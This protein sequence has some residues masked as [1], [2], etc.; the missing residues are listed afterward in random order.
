[1][2]TVIGINATHR[3]EVVKKI[4]QLLSDEFVLFVKTL[5]AHWN[6]EGNDFYNKHSF[7]E[8][9]YREMIDIIDNVAERIRSLGHYAPATLHEFA[10]LTRLSESKNESSDGISYIKSLLEGHDAILFFIREHLAEITDRYKDAG[11]G[12]F[13][14]GLIETHEKMS[15][16]LRAQLS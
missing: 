15:W 6:V 1:M 5:N 16:K 14:T 4:C 3:H 7:F 9:Q 12:D 13:L 11:T 2:E 8:I 10:A